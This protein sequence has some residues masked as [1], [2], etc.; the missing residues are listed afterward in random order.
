M[1]HIFCGAKL[2]KKSHIRKK[3]RAKIIF[4]CV[5]RKNVVPLQPI[6]EVNKG[7]EVYM[8]ALQFAELYRNLGMIAED[9]TMMLKVAK[10]VRKLSKQMTK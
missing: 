8:T 1:V 2:Q 9:E 3:K 7:K 6:L 10:Y 5:C 4:I